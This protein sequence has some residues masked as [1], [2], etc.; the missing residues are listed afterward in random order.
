VREVSTLEL[1]NAC[2][3][4]NLNST[5]TST[6]SIRS[7]A[8]LWLGAFT[9]FYRP[10]TEEVRRLDPVSRFL[11]AARSVILVISAQ[12]ALLSGLLALA[13]RRF[14]AL[15]FILVLVGLV[16][17]HMISN[18][19]NDYFGY[20]RGHDTPDSPRM[21]YT[22]HPLASGVLEPRALLAGLA[23]LAAVCLTIAA[24]FIVTRGWTAAAF[25]AAG[26]VVLFLYDAAPVPLK[27]VGLGEIAVFV[28][29]GP[30]MVG[31]G[32][33]MIAGEISANAFY[34]SVPY[35]L[36]VMSILIGKHIDQ[37]DFDARHGIRTLP[38]LLGERAARALNAAIV[39]LMYI[40]TAALIGS[41]RLTPLASIVLV[42]LPRAARALSVMS[43]TRPASPP[44]GY[45]GWPLWYHR[46]CL[47]HN[48]MF[49]WLYLLGIAGGVAILPR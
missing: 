30:L 26:A 21:R 38:V 25:A 12:A 48:R 45:V 15:A 9:G 6:A 24:Y 29:W 23:A 44:A 4:E 33:A 27:S 43:R 41:G 13:A 42:A 39:V 37:L 7:K 40:V 16:A 49:G 19:S 28:V 11:Y 5:R 17:A 8:A 47:T 18:L 3:V 14:D 34:A 36:G 46:V 35:G 32:F 1:H 10:G 22:V 20:K 2:A 31:G